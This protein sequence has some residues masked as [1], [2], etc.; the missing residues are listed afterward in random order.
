VLEKKPKVIVVGDRHARS[1]AAELTE[2]LGKTS[3]VIGYVMPGAS[4]EVITDIAEEEI[5]KL[6]QK[7]VVIVWKG[8]NDTKKCFKR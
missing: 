1:C 6:T 2:N 8:T 4:S 5:S 7:G 3:E